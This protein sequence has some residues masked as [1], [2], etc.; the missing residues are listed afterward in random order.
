VGEDKSNIGLKP[1]VKETILFYAKG[2]VI[3]LTKVPNFTIILK[4]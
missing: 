2:E 1:N 4:L 3:L